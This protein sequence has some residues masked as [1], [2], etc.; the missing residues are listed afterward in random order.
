MKWIELIR[1]RSSAATLQ[2]ALAGL[3]TL[4]AGIAETTAEAMVLQHA[5]Y[6]GDLAF[7]IVWRTDARPV[8]SRTGLAVADTLRTLGSVDHAVWCPTGTSDPAPRAM[9]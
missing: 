5:L 4:A 3:E 7:V 9:G 6:D 1:V 8:K 2:S